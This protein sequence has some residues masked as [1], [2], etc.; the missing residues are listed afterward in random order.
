M[1]SRADLIERKLRQD[2]SPTHLEVL[3]E[4]AQHAGHAGVLESQHADTDA[5]TAGSAGGTHYRI[6]VASAKFDGLKLVNKHRLIYASLQ[7][8]IDQGVHALAIEVLDH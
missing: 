4:S 5:D 1:T 8:F 3:D 6:R 7:T 2:L